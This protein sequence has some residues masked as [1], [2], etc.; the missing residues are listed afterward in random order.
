MQALHRLAPDG[1]AEALA[2]AGRPPGAAGEAIRYALGGPRPR[3]AEPFAVAAAWAVR[4]GDDPP[5]GAAAP[6]A[7]PQAGHARPPHAHRAPVAVDDYRF[8]VDV[9]PPVRTPPLE[10]PSAWLPALATAGDNREWGPTW[11]TRPCRSCSARGRAPRRS[12]PSRP[13]TRY[14]GEPTADSLTGTSAWL[15]ALAAPG[16]PVGPIG[17]LLLAN[18][19]TAEDK[20][21]ATTAQETLAAAIGDGRVDAPV[22]TAPLRFFSAN[23]WAHAS[24]LGKRLAAVARLGPLHAETVR[25]AI[26]GMLLGDAGPARRA[27]FMRCSSR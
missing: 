23:G 27:T 18:A 15:V 8:V 25:L 3:S 20:L 6:V 16:A 9:E 13:S 22:L 21:T 10:Q 4:A 1:R 19:L 26:E 14:P 24:R 7:A 12:A 2:A 11:A 5:A 17:A